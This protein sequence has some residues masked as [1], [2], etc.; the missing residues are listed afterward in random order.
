M[1]SAFD[2]SINNVIIRNINARTNYSLVRLLNH[3]GKKL[4]NIL[5]DGVTEDEEREPS[6]EKLW[7]QADPRKKYLRTGATI[8]IGENSYYGDGI[9][10]C[11]EDTYNITVKN[12]ISRGRMGVRIACAL[13]DA[14]IENIQMYRNGGTAVYFGGGEMKNIIVRDIFYP[15]GV[16][17]YECDDNRLEENVNSVYFPVAPNREICAVYF[18][19]S[20]V[21]NT[22]IQNIFA[23]EFLTSVFGAIG[24]TKAVINASNIIRM[25]SE[26]PVMKLSDNSLLKID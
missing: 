16:V 14:C 17:A 23:G 26:T 7:E 2:T 12:V 21:S 1:E 10:A 25:N 18:K 15:Q 5:I 9:K 19:D 11:A 6:K 13:S 24:K 4:Y 20:V 8:R 3:N 22:I